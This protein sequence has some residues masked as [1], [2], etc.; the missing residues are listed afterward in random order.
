MPIIQETMESIDLQPQPRQTMGTQIPQAQA[1]Q[2]TPEV[3]VS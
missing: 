2:T 1:Q 3:Q